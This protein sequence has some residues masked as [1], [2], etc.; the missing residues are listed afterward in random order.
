MAWS[1]VADRSVLETGSGPGEVKVDR[2]PQRQC[3]LALRMPS[4]FQQSGCP[5]VIN[6]TAG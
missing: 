2:A 1:T 4:T 3:K 6:T 5:P